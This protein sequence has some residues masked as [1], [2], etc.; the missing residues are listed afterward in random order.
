MKNG[1]ALLEKTQQTCFNSIQL[2]IIVN[3]FCNVMLHSTHIDRITQYSNNQIDCSISHLSQL[4]KE[5]L[6]FGNKPIH[7][8][9]FLS[10]TC[11]AGFF[12]R[13]ENWR[14]SRST[15]D[16]QKLRENGTLMIRLGDQLQITDMPTPS[17]IEHSDSPLAP[18]HLQW[19]EFHLESSLSFDSATGSTTTLFRL[20]KKST[21]FGLIFATLLLFPRTVTS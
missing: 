3:T 15:Y 20:C 8:A 19:R 10:E 6:Q 12:E 13:E 16:H 11:N 2:E 4:R 9:I 5:V 7:V 21:D 18:L 1:T 17:L 14:Q